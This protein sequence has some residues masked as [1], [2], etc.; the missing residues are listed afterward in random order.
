MSV[1]LGDRLCAV[2][3]AVKMFLVVNL[4][5]GRTRFVMGFTIL[6]FLLIRPCSNAQKGLIVIVQRIQRFS[7]F[8][9]DNSDQKEK[10]GINF[11]KF[12]TPPNKFHLQYTCTKFFK[13]TCRLAGN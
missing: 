4:A 11:L 2:G 8:K 7:R 12:F 5:F 3:A 13:H 10:K 6:A 9:E 1:V